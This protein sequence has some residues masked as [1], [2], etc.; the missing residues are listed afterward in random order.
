MPAAAQQH[1]ST[2]ACCRQLTNYL[3]QNSHPYVCRLQV[4]GAYDGWPSSTST[5]GLQVRYTVQ[6]V[7]VSPWLTNTT[8]TYTLTVDS[9]ML[10]NLNDGVLDINLQVLGA[11]RMAFKPWPA[12]LHLKR[13]RA[14]SPLVPVMVGD[15]VNSM[16]NKVPAVTRVARSDRKAAGKDSL[17][18]ILG[19][20]VRV[21]S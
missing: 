1:I 9:P 20:E 16:A 12:F 17:Y 2:P 21:A 5:A 11:S 4:I 7:P 3:A 13:N 15:S 19:L 6:D 8:W 14:I 18:H 10:A